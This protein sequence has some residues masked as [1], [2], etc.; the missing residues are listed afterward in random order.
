MFDIAIELV[1]LAVGAFMLAVSIAFTVVKVLGW[2][3]LKSRLIYPVSWLAFSLVLVSKGSGF[4]YTLL[5]NSLFG[6]VWLAFGFALCVMVV[7]LGIR[8]IIRFGI[9][10]FEWKD[11]PRFFD[12]KKLNKK[13]HSRKQNGLRE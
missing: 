12:N 3:L 13:L 4:L 8:D 1:S 7:V 5:I 11:I 10:D 6:Y 2:V 9:P